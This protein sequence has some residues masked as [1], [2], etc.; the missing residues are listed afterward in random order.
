[1]ATVNEIPRIHRWL[2]TILAADATLVSAAPGGIWRGFVPKGKTGTAV[3]FDPM[4]PLDDTPGNAGY[5]VWS[6]WRYVVKAVSDGT[7]NNDSTLQTAADRIE[8]VLEAVKGGAADIGIDYCIRKRPFYMVEQ[9]T[10]SDVTYIHLGGEF[11]IAAH[12]AG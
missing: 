5:R 11:E 10:D 1:M 4:A 9:P 12:Y 8:A 7:S 2:K 3:V 6:R